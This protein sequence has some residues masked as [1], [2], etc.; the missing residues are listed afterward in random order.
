MFFKIDGLKNFAIFTG[1]QMYWS[2]FLINLKEI[3]RL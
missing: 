1:K 2:Y 3:K